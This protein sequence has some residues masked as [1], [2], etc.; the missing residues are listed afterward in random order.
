[1]AKNYVYS[2][3]SLPWTNNGAETVPGGTVIVL[4]G[5]IGVAQGDIPPGFS[6]QVA[7]E[8]VWKIKKATAAP[9]AI[10]QKCYFDPTGSQITD[11]V[12]P[13]VKYAGI[14]AA[15]AE[16]DATVCEVKLNVYGGA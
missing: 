12:L 7:T 11:T 10:G 9:L 1:M 15:P 6:G 3:K 4:C 14:A 5:I 16:A 8:H 13:G 2:G